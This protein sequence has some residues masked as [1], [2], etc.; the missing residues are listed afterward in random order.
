MGKAAATVLMEGVVLY[1]DPV[2]IPIFLPYYSP[3]RTQ[4]LQCLFHD[5]DPHLSP[6]H[7]SRTLPF[8]HLQR[9]ILSG[10]RIPGVSRHGKAAE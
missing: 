9:R 2:L 1:P 5:Q 10:H 4:V 3:V 6:N 7:L 8:L